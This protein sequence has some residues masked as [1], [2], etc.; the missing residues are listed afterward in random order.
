MRTLVPLF[1]ATAMA[2]SLSAQPPKGKGKREPPKNLKI[3][4]PDNYLAAMR[5]F[6]VAL[7]VDCNFCHVQGDRSSDA[8]PQKNTARMMLQMTRDINAKINA[9]IPAAG[10]ERHVACYTCHRG[11]Q[12]PLTEPPA[13]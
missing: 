2:L 6:T 10:N 4:T 7:G 9:A 12:K 8:K 5:S 13:N 1:L 3:L 11:S